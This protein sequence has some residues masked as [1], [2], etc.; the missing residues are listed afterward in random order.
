VASACV[1]RILENTGENSGV[2]AAAFEKIFEN[3][4]KCV[5]IW[6]K[7]GYNKME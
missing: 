6:G 5:C 1:C 3:R 2:G 7:M 4:K